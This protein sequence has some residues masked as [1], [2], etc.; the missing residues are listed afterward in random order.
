MRSSSPCAFEQRPDSSPQFRTIIPLS[1]K[2]GSTLPSNWRESLRSPPWCCRAA[3]KWS[4]PPLRVE[5]LTDREERI[6]L[7]APYE[8]QQP[9]WQQ[10]ARQRHF[11]KAP[12]RQRYRHQGNAQVLDRTQF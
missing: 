8:S 10:R 12:S 9:D 5:G 3:T 6:E 4:P 7:E 11:I 2:Y 1:A